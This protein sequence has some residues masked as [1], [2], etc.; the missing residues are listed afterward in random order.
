[1]ASQ[2]QPGLRP[3]RD[4]GRPGGMEVS[5]EPRAIRRP[6]LPHGRRDPAHIQDDRI[7]TAWARAGVRR[8]ATARQ[9]SKASEASIVVKPEAATRTA[10]G[11]AILSY[12]TGALPRRLRLGHQ[13][14]HGQMVTHGT[15]SCA[16]R[17]CSPH[18]GTTDPCG[19]HVSQD[20]NDGAAARPGIAGR[21]TR[22]R[23]ANA[24]HHPC[25]RERPAALD[26]DLAG[27]A[28][29]TRSGLA[30]SWAS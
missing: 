14:V 19:R 8:I 22:E 5:K 12:G 23:D 28:P 21:P 30:G 10:G 4:G 16:L 3:P 13:A 27:T 6:A 17:H 29:L 20:G 24:R 1:M 26:R 25:P 9:A 7:V 11:P 2:H 15:S 18:C